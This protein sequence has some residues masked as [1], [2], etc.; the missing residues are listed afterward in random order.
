MSVRVCAIPVE[1]IGEVRPGD[2]VAGL[3][4]AALDAQGCPLVEGDILVVTHK[5]I[6]KAEG[7]LI[8]LTG[9]RPRP[10]ARRWAARYG[11]DPRAIE[12][13]FAQS[14]RIVRQRHGVLIAETCHGRHGFVCANS[15][16]DL[17]NVDGG[18][19]AALLPNDPDRCAAALHRALRR[20]TR[21]YIPV[22]ITDSFGRP[23][24]EGLTEAA[25]GVA[26]MRVFRD[27]RGQ[28]DPYGYQLRASSEA[29]ADELAGLAGLACGKLTRRP[30]C[31]VRGFAYVRGRGRALDIIRPPERDLFR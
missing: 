27:L 11:Y 24:R 5:I 6:S 19:S 20:R 30:A 28:R 2:S 14:R 16:V 18:R 22:I 10:R 3:I 12:L 15:G 7:Q 4:L 17:S 25:I 26:G 8:P 1:G 9:V 31:I 13:V 21:L 23:W 29:V